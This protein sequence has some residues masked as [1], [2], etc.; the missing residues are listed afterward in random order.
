MVRGKKTIPAVVAFAERGGAI[1][2]SSGCIRS[3]KPEQPGA[4]SDHLA[5]FVL[6]AA[7]GDRILGGVS[8]VT[9]GI[10]LNIL[11]LLV[12]AGIIWGAYAE[13]ARANADR[14]A[15]VR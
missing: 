9:A 6:D 8:A 5:R 1:V 2:R 10:I 11:A 13:Q 14:D 4:G 12:S 3:R 7:P 15:R